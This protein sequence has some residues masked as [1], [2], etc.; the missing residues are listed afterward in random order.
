MSAYLL[1]AIR[2]QPDDDLARLA[3]ADWL[4]ENDEADRA[5]FVRLHLQLDLQET[6]SPAAGELNAQAE[7]LAAA[8][9]RRWLGEW[10]ELLVNWSFRRGFLDSVTLEPEVF[11]SRGE[12]LF[13][14]QPIREVRFVGSGGDPAPGEIA[15]EIVASPLF[16]RVRAVNASGAWPSAAPLWCR[17]LA[18]A[19]TVAGLE[20]LNFGS[21]WIPGAIFDDHDAF[22]AL[23]ESEHL[24]S[25]KKLDLSA[26]LS[27]GSFGDEAVAFLLAAPFFP[28]LQDL[29]LSGWQI[30]DDGLRALITGRRLAHLEEFDLSWCE[31]LSRDGLRALYESK[32]LPRLSTLCLGGDVDVSALARAPLLAGLERLDLCTAATRHLR[33]FP[34]GDWAEFAASPNVARLRRLTLLHAILDEAGCRA[35]FQ[36]PGPLSLF[37]LMLMGGNEAMAPI[38]AKS[39]ALGPLTALE[40]VTCG[41]GPESVRTLLEAPFV[42][43]LRQFCVAGNPIQ[44]RGLHAILRSPLKDGRLDDFHLHHCT[45]PPGAL[46][47]LFSWPGLANVTR[48][49]LGSNNLDADAMTALLSSRHLGRLT[50]LHVGSGRVSEE[51]LLALAR[52]AALPRLRDVTVGGSIGADAVD[53][54]RDRFGARLKVDPRG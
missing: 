35:L 28:R 18:R 7:A 39:P 52:S 29:S 27:D 49:E 34:P 47:K 14:T 51:G 20:E 8:H 37:S 38:L 9:E 12:E 3:Y 16:A 21:A 45:L 17:A 19:E 53:A 2:E 44:S 25:L 26:P 23:C 32:K 5:Q 4:E 54:L 33:T 36:T 15:E 31:R 11:L 22:R 10:A 48:L 30:S 6:R 40:L 43:N 13:A 50:T 46:K 1:A 41:F 24:R 42:P